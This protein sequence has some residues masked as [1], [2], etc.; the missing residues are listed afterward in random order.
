MSLKHPAVAMHLSANKCNYHRAMANPVSLKILRTS[1]VYSVH[2]RF[3]VQ[4]NLQ[5]ISNLMKFAKVKH[6]SVEPSLHSLHSE[7]LSN[8]NDRLRTS[9]TTAVLYFSNGYN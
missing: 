8:E 1:L 3:S 9:F 5:W 7:V 6:K 2:T 4:E